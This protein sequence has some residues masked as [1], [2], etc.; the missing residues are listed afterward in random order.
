MATATRQR[1]TAKGKRTQELIFQTAVN[2]ASVEGLAGLTIGRLAAELKMSKSGLFGH[3][4]SKERL[5][6]DTIEAA[7]R[8]F[9]NEV[10]KSVRQV[11]SGLARL[12]A[13]CD[14]WLSYLERRVFTGGCFFVAASFEFDSRPGPIRDVIAANNREW[15]AYLEEAIRQSQASGEIKTD[16]EPDQITF[17]LYALKVG[18][19]WALHLYDDPTA[20]D[21]ARRA[22]LDR[23]RM[24]ATGAA[25]ALPTL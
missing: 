19:N 11:D 16:I 22:I 24:L 9:I 12:W 17:E 20:P 25:P 21:R 23:L 5:Q 6:L 1:R 3:F 7:R 4:G 13:L 18:A 14:S 10:V 15:L 8:I 2:I